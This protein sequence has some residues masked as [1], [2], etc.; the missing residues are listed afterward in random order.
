MTSD[1]EWDDAK[2][3]SNKR[4]HG[5]TFEEAATVFGDALAVI[6]DD[7]V[8]STGEAREI[9][10]AIPRRAGS[11]SFPSPNDPARFASSALAG[12]RSRNGRTMK[13]ARSSKTPQKTDDDLLPEYRFDYRKAR[14]NRFAKRP[15]LE[16][17][18]DP[19][20][21]DVFTTPES[22]NAVLRA[23][24]ETMPK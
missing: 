23:L 8:H 6:F 7:E 4:K 12:P 22:V 5:V 1:F 2:S 18:L 3:A 15:G 16:V 21:A 19:D 17:T 24:I 11:C 20:V 9:R 13:K 10:S 14:P